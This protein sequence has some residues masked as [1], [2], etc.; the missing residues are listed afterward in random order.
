MLLDLFDRKKARR[1]LA[2]AIFMLVTLLV[3]NT[4]LSRITILGVKALFLPAACV[5]AGMFEGGV[6]GAV[7][8]LFLG[9]FG[10]M[11]Y[12]ENTVLFTVLFPMIGFFTGFAAEFFLNRRFLPF[13]A[14]S[15]AAILLTALCQAVTA[16]ILSGGSL[17]YM[18][19]TA[20][21]QTLWSLP[22]AALFYPAA[23]KMS[24]RL[25]GGPRKERQ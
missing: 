12:S 15:L 24:A 18:L 2:W 20:G 14:A 23:A 13:M 9:F 25:G 7:F 19:R 6:G 5:A 8:G 10:D 1:A 22:P 3:Q 16:A 4:V 11:S 21:L 17:G